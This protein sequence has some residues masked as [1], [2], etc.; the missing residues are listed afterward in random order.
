MKQASLTSFFFILLIVFNFISNGILAL[1][2]PEIRYS[3]YR[4]PADHWAVNPEIDGTGIAY[5]TYLNKYKYYIYLNPQDRRGY[6]IIVR[7]ISNSGGDIQSTLNRAYTSEENEGL[8]EVSALMMDVYH[9]MGLPVV[10]LAL[11]GNNAQ[12]Y[13]ANSNT[14]IIGTEKEPG[15]LHLHMWARGDTNYEYISGV[16]L[17][18]PELGTAFDMTNGKVKWE[19]DLLKQCLIIFKNTFES[20][21]DNKNS[22]NLSYQLI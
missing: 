3:E 16:K 15:F 14:I 1:P 9:R 6:R 21:F 7:Y 17:L 18:G 5:V 22:F 2:A 12:Q 13:D 20:S 8:F 19:N 10:Q 11:A 4:Y